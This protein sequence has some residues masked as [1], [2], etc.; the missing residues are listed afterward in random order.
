MGT[1]SSTSDSYD[2]CHIL[3]QT[4]RRQ[5]LTDGFI[6]SMKLKKIVPNDIKSILTSY[7]QDMKT[8][9]SRTEIEEEI[10]EVTIH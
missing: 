7:L 6:R 2:F 9:K 5:R 4:Q 10:K 3:S 1:S 8:I